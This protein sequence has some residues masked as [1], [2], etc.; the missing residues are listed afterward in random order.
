M[1]SC[2]LH[3]RRCHTGGQEGSAQFAKQTELSLPS[4]VV[5]ISTAAAAVPEDKEEEEAD[6][7]PMGVDSRYLSRCSY[8]S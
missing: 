8:S 3:R 5:A 4:C 1:L 7:V 6:N 2:N